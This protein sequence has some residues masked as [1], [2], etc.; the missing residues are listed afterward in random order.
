MVT[1]SH[2]IIEVVSVGLAMSEQQRVMCD[3]CR[4]WYKPRGLARHRNACPAISLSQR[5]AQDSVSQDE[6]QNTLAPDSSQNS[7]SQPLAPQP[8]R[9]NQDV[10]HQSFQQETIVQVME[11]LQQA[12]EAEYVNDSG[13]VANDYWE[14]MW[15]MVT[16]LQGRQYELPSGAIGNQSV[17]LLAK[18]IEKLVSGEFP[19]ERLLVCVAVIL[20]RDKSVKQAKDI[21]VVIGRRLQLWESGQ[22][23][24]LVDEAVSLDKKI[25]RRKERTS[26]QFAKTFH[27]LI[28]RGKVREAVRWLIEGGMKSLLQPDSEISEGRT[29]ID[30]LLAKHPEPSVPHPDVLGIPEGQGLPPLMHVHITSDHVEAVARRLR[31]GGGPNGANS[32]Q[33]IDF[34]LR[35]G[36]SSVHLREAVAALANKLGNEVVP[37]S[38]VRALLS[39]R[40]VALDKCPGVRP[41]GIGDCLRRIICKC[42]AAATGDEVTEACGFEQLCGGL[43]AGI[44]GAVHAMGNLFDERAVPGSNWGFLLVDA[45]NAFNAMNRIVALWQARRRWPKCARFLFNTYRG[46]AQLVLRGSRETLLSKEGVTQGDPLAMLFYA[47]STLPIIEQLRDPEIHQCWYAD[48]SSAQ[49]EFQKLKEW[50]EK[51]GVLG[52]THGYFPQ[53]RKSYLVVHPNDKPEAKRIFA[54]TGIKIVTGQRY[55]GGF[56]GQEDDELQFMNKKVNDLV[57]TVKKLSSVGKTHPQSAYTAFIKSIRFKWQFLQRVVKGAENYMEPLKEAIR[58]DFIPAIIG[59]DKPSEIECDLFSLPVS[60]GH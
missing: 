60:K 46:H 41:I 52:P 6:T 56:I 23:G 58:S 2:K 17:E 4:G 1:R 36:R 18:E 50:W 12:F 22:V 14:S 28:L 39:S 32:E 5:M 42:M 34:L 10:S 59:S 44:E 51:L 43:S 3:D 9:S 33:W 20:Q 31:G 30:E 37:W 19:S 38:A 7:G 45:E 57:E 11:K 55:L 47:I 27:R 26:D 54:G 13:E 40:L 35:R 53:G 25:G 24:I 48:D 21:R 8:M 49:G 29:V 16:Q 15:S